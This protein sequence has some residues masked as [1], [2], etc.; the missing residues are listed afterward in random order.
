MFLILL[1]FLLLCCRIHSLF[2]CQTLFSLP[3]SCSYSVVACSLMY[4][5][6]RSSCSGFLQYTWNVKAWQFAC[7]L[8]NYYFLLRPK[9]IIKLGLC[10]KCATQYSWSSNLSLQ[11]VILP[12]SLGCSLVFAVLRN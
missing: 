2:Q 10:S 4:S 12:L 9:F 7:I 1:S 6:F 11:I 8:C 3:L 5:N